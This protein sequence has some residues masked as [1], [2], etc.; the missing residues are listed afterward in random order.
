MILPGN[1]PYG[2]VWARVPVSERG[3]DKTAEEKGNSDLQY[4]S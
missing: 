3:M 1:S 2:L 4:N